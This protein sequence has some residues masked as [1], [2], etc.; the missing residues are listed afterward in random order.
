M[1]QPGG[2]TLDPDRGRPEP[3]AV[4][5]ARPGLTPI[6]VPGTHESLVAHPAGLTQ[7]LLDA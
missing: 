4:F 2:Y 5:A 7:D 1:P 3:G 6:T